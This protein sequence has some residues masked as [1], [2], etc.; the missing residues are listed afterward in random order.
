MANLEPTYW[1]AE[2]D[3]SGGD[4]S[5]D[6]YANAKNLD[7][8]I[9]DIMNDTGT[10]TLA[11]DVEV[12]LCG[13]VN[14]GDQNIVLAGVLPTINR[15]GNTTHHITMAGY[16]YT[17]GT[18]RTECTVSANG[19]AF[20]VFPINAFAYN[21]WRDIHVTDTSGDNNEGWMF[22]SS[23]GHYN[24][25]INC[26][27]SD[28]FRGWQS[29]ATAYTKYINCQAFGNR[30]TGIF[31][32]NLNGCVNCS[33]WDNT[34]FGFAGGYNTR[35]F[36]YESGGGS[37]NYGFYQPMTATECVARG[38]NNDGF[39]LSTTSI[40]VLVDCI[41]TD[42]GESGY[43]Y[44]LA[45]QAVYLLRCADYNNTQGRFSTVK[46][47]TL[48]DDI[49]EINLTADPF[50]DAANGDFSL[51]NNAGGGAMLRNS[52]GIYLPGNTTKSFHDVGCSQHEDRV[53]VSL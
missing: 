30:H 24:L 48:V 46:A 7:D 4:G 20:D 52:T 9:T 45:T 16:D 37:Q 11:S 3:K 34:G 40:S 28:A 36:S 1:V 17:A 47:G 33:V 41:A 12:R 43:D 23:S 38:V 2:A 49:D 25:F 51:N 50:I 8:F 18:T 44:H 14:D 42:C 35:C 31:N 10:Y 53:I 19:G 15:S 29:N 39:F 6:S 21:I 32:G 5:G 22:T 26:R 27:A 13:D